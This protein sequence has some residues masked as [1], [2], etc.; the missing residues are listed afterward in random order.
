MNGFHK[1]FHVV[2]KHEKADFLVKKFLDPVIFWSIISQIIDQK[3]TETKISQFPKIFASLPA[4]HTNE[5]L[6]FGR[7]SKSF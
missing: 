1:F 7:S 6:K 5:F 2:D 4:N 3:M